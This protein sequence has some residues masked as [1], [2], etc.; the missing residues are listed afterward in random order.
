MDDHGHPG[1][2]QLVLQAFH[3]LQQSVSGEVR[4]HETLKKRRQRWCDGDGNAVVLMIVLAMMAM[5]RVC[6]SRSDSDGDDA[7]QR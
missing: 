2:V 4:A 7:G 3:Q 1:G 5:L 6:G